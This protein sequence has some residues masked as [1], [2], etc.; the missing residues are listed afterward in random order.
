AA[1]GIVRLLGGEETL[2]LSMAPKSATT[3][4]ALSL[5][6]TYGGLP[7]I[8]AVLTILTGV[9]GALFG[10]W[11]LDRLAV[12]DPRARGLA[13]GTSSH[14]IGLARILGGHPVEGAYG[15]L[16]MALTALTTS[17][18]MPLVLPL[19]GL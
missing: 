8:T 3:P 13:I 12:R 5:I 17:L 16:A 10:P 7:A 4:V 6:E 14:G 2:E 19:F 18:L 1:I 15:S 11:V 9:L